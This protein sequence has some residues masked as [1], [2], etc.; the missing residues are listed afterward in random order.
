MTNKLQQL[1]R[2]FY[3]ESL[4]K[5]CNNILHLFSKL[6]NDQ[7]NLALEPIPF[8]MK[9]DKELSSVPKDIEVSS[10]NSIN[11][12]IKNYTKLSEDLPFMPEKI[13]YIHFDI[14][15]LKKCLLHDDM[16]ES[17]IQIFKDLAKS[18]A[19]IRN[20]Q[21]SVEDFLSRIESKKIKSIFSDLLEEDKINFILMGTSETI[22]NFTGQSSSSRKFHQ[23]TEKYIVHDLCHALYDR[24]ENPIGR[25]QFYPSKYIANYLDDVFQEYDYIQSSYNETSSKYKINFEPYSKANMGRGGVLRFT[26]SPFDVIS[27]SFRRRDG[28]YS[29]FGP[30][31][32]RKLVGLN[33]FTDKSDFAQDICASLLTLKDKT[34]E[35][36]YFEIIKKLFSNWSIP[37]K[38]LY[39]KSINTDTGE[40]ERFSIFPEDKLSEFKD[41]VQTLHSRMVDLI[42]KEMVAS[43]SSEAGYVS[44]I[45]KNNQVV[46]FNMIAWD[47]GVSTMSSKD[48]DKIK[49]VHTDLINSNEL[50][51]SGVPILKSDMVPVPGFSENPV[52]VLFD[53]V[54]GI[55]VHSLP[56]HRSNYL[57]KVYEKK[58]KVLKE[59]KSFVVR[60]QDAD[61]DGWDESIKEVVSVGDIASAL[62]SK[63]WKNEWN[64]KSLCNPNGHPFGEECPAGE[65]IYKNYL[66]DR[67]DL[68][69]PNSIFIVRDEKYYK[70]TSTAWFIELDKEDYRN[71]Y[72]YRTF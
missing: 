47:S 67:H 55:I 54:E 21:S 51:I 5:E 49:E 2:F 69:D 42:A 22:N 35:S 62:D 68:V 15:K 57:K 39:Q 26:N 4:Y 46:I 52:K 37:T 27:S 23:I 19:N 33:S 20:V 36:N 17:D 13:N 14:N 58:K 61:G 64:P 28:A 18:I 10:C 65:V 1:Y 24:N 48:Y 38:L 12:G 34:N 9:L 32:F 40:I 6:S 41:I 63:G 43:T 70:H 30:F 50:L 71:F 53:G 60:Y 45:L 72:S 3:K 29:R 31:D 8:Q 66:P 16:S 56:K 7:E 25:S 44:K 59:F 11:F